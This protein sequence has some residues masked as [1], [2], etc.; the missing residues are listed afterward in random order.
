[1]LF[2]ILL[3]RGSL[4]LWVSSPLVLGISHEWP[5]ALGG[6]QGAEGLYCDGSASKL[7][8][9]NAHISLFLQELELSRNYFRSSLMPLNHR[10][11]GS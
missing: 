4:P 5:L 11:A 7:R 3:Q 10:R 9:R 6:K 1:M 2:G 8:L